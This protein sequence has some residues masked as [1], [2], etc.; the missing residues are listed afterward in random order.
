MEG[1]R[2]RERQRERQRETERE[3]AIQTHTH[4]HTHTHTDDCVY[5][6][7]RILGGAPPRFKGHKKGVCGKRVRNICNMIN[8]RGVIELIQGIVHTV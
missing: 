5:V 8:G 4:T 3:T 6:R 1:E 2:E 7:W